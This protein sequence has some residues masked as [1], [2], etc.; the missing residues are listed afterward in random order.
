[1]ERSLRR[2]SSSNR[3]VTRSLGSYS[4]DLHSNLKATGL[5]SGLPRCEEPRRCAEEPDVLARTSPAQGSAPRLRPRG[6]LAEKA[7]H[8]ISDCKSRSELRDAHRFPITNVNHTCECSAVSNVGRSPGRS[9]PSP[10]HEHDFA[11]RAAQDQGQQ[12]GGSNGTRANDPNFHSLLHIGAP[13]S[14][15]R[16]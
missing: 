15:S 2:R 16:N 5:Q 6:C 12:A 8:R 10:I 1:M 7:L 14:C 3:Q 11:R 4:N 13:E 9:L